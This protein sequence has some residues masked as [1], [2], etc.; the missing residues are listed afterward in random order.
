MII[1]ARKAR[2]AT[3]LLSGA[4]SMKAEKQAIAVLSSAKESQE[5][6]FALWK[7]ASEEVTDQEIEELKARQAIH[8]LCRALPPTPLISPPAVSMLPPRLSSVLQ[9]SLFKPQ[10]QAGSS[11]W[12]HQVS[13]CHVHKARL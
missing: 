7:E 11:Y 10:A 13:H 6:D 9:K 2:H 1:A 5:R 4:G 12:T 8:V 3:C